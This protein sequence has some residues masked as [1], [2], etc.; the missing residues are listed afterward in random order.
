MVA[1][2]RGVFEDIKHVEVAAIFAAQRSGFEDVKGV[3]VAVMFA[4]CVLAAIAAIFAVKG[5]I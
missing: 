3:E 2:E 4:R 5:W 1:A